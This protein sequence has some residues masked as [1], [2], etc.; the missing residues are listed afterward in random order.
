M[1]RTTRVLGLALF[2]TVGCA[3]G[4]QV[5][6]DGGGGHPDGG[7]DSDAAHCGGDNCDQDNDGVNDGNDQCPD[8]P[9]GDPVNSVGCSD[10][11]VNPT[12]NTDFPPYSLT[13]IPTGDPG[14]AG[15]LTWTYTNI[16]RG[17]LFHIYWVV[18]DDPA[19]PCGLSLDG[20][21][22]TAGESWTYDAADSNLA[23]GLLVLTNTTHILLADSTSPQLTGR[24]TLTIVDA[25]DVPTP[26]AS[27]ATLGITGRS[28]QYG[29]EIPGLGFKVQAIIEVADASAN[30]TPYLDYYDAASTPDT[31]GGASVSLGGSF[32][33][34]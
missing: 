11:Q 25:N 23:G 4:Q 34:E 22:D 29:A 8:T 1:S 10:A 15:G 17:D 5:D 3:K 32:Y 26:F 12:L 31:G 21:I 18:C 27:L 9:S 2:A 33:D 20:P 13:W 28:G 6:P 7:N 30:W 24:L 16:D 14:R 19:D